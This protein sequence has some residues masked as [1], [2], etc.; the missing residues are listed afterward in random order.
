METEHVL[1]TS[2]VLT[3]AFGVVRTSEQVV[4]HHGV[5]TRTDEV[6][7]SD[8]ACAPKGSYRKRNVY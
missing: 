3:L 8:I 7:S 4:Q 1:F 2:S 6:L 5:G